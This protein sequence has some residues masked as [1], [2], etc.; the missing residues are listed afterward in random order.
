MRR[1][2]RRPSCLHSHRIHRLRQRFHASNRAR[3]VPS[4]P[5]HPPASWLYI[6]SWH[7]CIAV[8]VAPVAS[9]AYPI[10]FG[11]FNNLSTVRIDLDA[12]YCLL[13]ASMASRG[14]MSIWCI[15]SVNALV[16]DVPR[17][18]SITVYVVWPAVSLLGSSGSS[19]ACLGEFSSPLH[20]NHSL[21][22]SDVFLGFFGQFPASSTLPDAPNASIL[23]LVSWFSELITPFLSPSSS[24]LGGLSGRCT[25][26]TYP[27]LYGL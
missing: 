27:K 11:A 3:R 23:A 9:T 16:A 10:A 25:G 2:L 26:K 7:V 12:S 17:A 15:R 6:P 18:F 8:A 14:S 1:S 20:S 22:H 5:G 19:G 4:P 13:L 21:T 24:V